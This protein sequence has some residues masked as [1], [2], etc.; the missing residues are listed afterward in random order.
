MRIAVHIHIFL[1]VMVH[2]LGNINAVGS[3]CVHT[4]VLPRECD[5]LSEPVGFASDYQYIDSFEHPTHI[6]GRDLG[7]S[8]NLE[9]LTKL[10]MNVLSKKKLLRCFVNDSRG[11]N[12]NLL[13][14]RLESLDRPGKP[15]LTNIDDPDK[16][17]HGSPSDQ[18]RHCLLNNALLKFE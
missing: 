6:G 14:K 7:N 18:G 2:T 4:D 12:Q 1:H 5:I 16:T 15:I 10:K 3:R 8:E 17:P 9:Y 11:R 13:V